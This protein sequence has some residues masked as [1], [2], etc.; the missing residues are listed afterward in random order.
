AILNIDET[1]HNDQGERLWTWC[2]RADLYTVF[3][4]DP[5]R[6]AD[7][8]IEVLGAEF[9]GVLGCDCFSAYRR[10][11]RQFDVRLQ[12]CLAHLIR[13]V[14][15]LTPVPDK[16]TRAYGE[17]F[18]EALR[19]L[20]EVVHKRPEMT[21]AAFRNRLEAAKAEVLRQATQDVP[22]TKAAANLALRMQKY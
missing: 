1:S 4:I 2:F 6:S 21:G 7:V 3:K 16:R 11:M 14:K 18:R 10:S 9:D 17:R 5:T 15:Y 19:R 20:F 13:E 12:L 22:A 8:L